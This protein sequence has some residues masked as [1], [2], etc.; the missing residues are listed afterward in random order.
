MHKI[1]RTIKRRR[2]EAKTDYNARL[3]MLK[4]GK[5]RLIVRKTNRYLIAQLV[6]SNLAQDKVIVGVSSKDLLGLGWPKELAGSLKN[7][8]ACYLT[9]MLLA[10]KAKGKEAILD[11]G[12]HR[13]ISGSRIY[14]LVKGAIDAGLKIPCSEESLPKI[15]A[16]DEKFSGIFEKIK[17]KL[18]AK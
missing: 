7:R 12:M 4:S 13:N 6:S 11:L 9:G 17:Q 5:T 10:S 2:L 15:E 1:G 18:G 3:S 14:A 16:K 8:I